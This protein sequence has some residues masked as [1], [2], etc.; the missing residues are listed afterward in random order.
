VLLRV[1]MVSVDPAQRA[2]MMSRTYRSQLQPGEIMPAFALGEVVHSLTPELNVGDIVEG[3]LGWQDWTVVT[4]SQVVRRDSR[5]PLERLIGVLN[6]AG[7]TAYF[8]LF[9]VGRIRAGETVV[10][11]GAAGSVGSLAVQ[12]ACIAGCRV[13]GIAGGADKC[14]RLKDQLGVDAV[15]DRK[16]DDFRDALKA[17]CPNGV[18]VYFDNT[19]GMILETALTLMNL[20]GRVICC[21][22]VAQY[23]SGNWGAG[24]AGVPGVLISRRIR[25]EGFICMD[26]DKQ[27]RSAEAALSH[28]MDTGRLTAPMHCVD[29]LEHAP[30][31][32]V[33]LLAGENFGKVAVLV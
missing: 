20:R 22:A 6:I 1:R 17:A 4:P 7:L 15:V 27:R 12:I 30:Q 24:V 9:E 26:F 28:W 16:A 25:M 31:A 18:D 8:G 33:D 19:G 10:V 2:W 14:S 23:D 29:G 11:S 3:D 21:G 13:V 5:Q 32:L